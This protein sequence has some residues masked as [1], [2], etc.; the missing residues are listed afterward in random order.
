MASRNPEQFDVGK[1]ASRSHTPATVAMKN[2]PGRAND[3]VGGK[4][5]FARLLH[6]IRIKAAA[7]SILNYN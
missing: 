1:V 4:V 2:H 6:K 5:N 3:E 7:N